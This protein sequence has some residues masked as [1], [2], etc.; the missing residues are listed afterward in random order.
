MLAKSSSLVPF[1]RKNKYFLCA[2]SIFRVYAITSIHAHVYAFLCQKE[3]GA[4]HPLAS[5]LAFCNCSQQDQQT[6][7]FQGTKDDHL[8]HL[9]PCS[10]LYVPS[11]FILKKYET[12]VCA[13][14]LQ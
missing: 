4:D 14:S 12:K 2:T 13:K 11:S 10:T 5:S 6:S 7:S 3:M 9:S 1:L 8:I